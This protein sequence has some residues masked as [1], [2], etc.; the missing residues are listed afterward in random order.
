[1]YAT[2]TR[3]ERTYL[4]EQDNRKRVERLEAERVA[5]DIPAEEA[6][7][8]REELDLRACGLS[9]ESVNELAECKFV[10]DYARMEEDRGLEGPD[11]NG[12]VGY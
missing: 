10:R 1:M 2:S 12:R 7:A 4:R 9:E 6:A 5:K 11:L 3:S 8:A